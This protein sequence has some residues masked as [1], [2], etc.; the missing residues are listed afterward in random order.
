M[1]EWS[2]L[3]VID[4]DRNVYSVLIT[5]FFPLSWGSLAFCMNSGILPSECHFYSYEFDEWHFS[6]SGIK[7]LYKLQ[8]LESCL[9]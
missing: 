9:C 1:H 6:S 4:T 8:L 2:L 3:V 7:R 5:V